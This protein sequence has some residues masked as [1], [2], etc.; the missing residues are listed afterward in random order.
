MRRCVL[1]MGAT[2]TVLARRRWAAIHRVDCVGFRRGGQDEFSLLA[3]R[4]GG[5]DGLERDCRG[6]RGLP[7]H[8]LALQA[9]SATQLIG[10]K[11]ILT[12]A[13]A[14][15][16]IRAA[17]LLQ[18]VDLLEDVPMNVVRCAVLVAAV[19]AATGCRSPYYADQGALTGGLAGA[20]IGALIGD[21][22][23]NAGA[24]ALIG[25]AVGATSGA[26]IGNGLDEIEARN[27]ALIQQSLGRQLAGAATTDDVV[28]MSQAGL[29]DEV[30][31]THLRV[32]GVARV[33]TADDLIRLKQ[34]QVS[35]RVLQA[36]QN[37]P[38]A[39]VAVSGPAVVEEHYYVAPP[40]VYG[41]PWRYRHHHHPRACR[42]GGVSWGLSMH[43]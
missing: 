27:Q 14:V 9:A 3:P 10:C 15:A 31:V 38:P 26:L 11:L 23:G 18:N 12:R 22:S 17:R 20:G 4:G 2:G 1:R 8:S 32:H 37:P 36:M 43:H 13:D 19:L 16:T 34:Q 24:G 30:I 33:P 21:A 25:S 39:A 40:P 28:A 6:I 35:D 29:S 41:P 5:A 7:N 42:P